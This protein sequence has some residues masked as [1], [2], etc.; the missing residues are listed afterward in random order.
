MRLRVM[1]GESGGM[2]AGMRPPRRRLQD[3]AGGTS[4]RSSGSAGNFAC[5]LMQ[6]GGEK[7]PAG[8]TGKEL[9]IIL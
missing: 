3:D 2:R 1:P 5:E 8:L 6:S 7:P 9:C 4:C